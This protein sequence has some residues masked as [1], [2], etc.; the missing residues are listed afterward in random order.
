MTSAMKA[1]TQAL[2]ERE[3]LKD[4]LLW[5][6]GWSLDLNDAERV[7]WKNFFLRCWEQPEQK[8]LRQQQA[9]CVS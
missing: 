7:A 3:A 2:G 9:W 6:W 4:C 1:I 8:G 5:R